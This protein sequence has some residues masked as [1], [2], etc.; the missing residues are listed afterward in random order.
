[1]LIETERF[2]TF[3]EIGLFKDSLRNKMV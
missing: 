3:F 2:R 1:M